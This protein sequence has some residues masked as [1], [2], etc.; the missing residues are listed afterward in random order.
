MRPIP[1]ATPMRFDRIAIRESASNSSYY[2]APRKR[3]PEAVDEKVRY[4]TVENL[5][6]GKLTFL[7]DI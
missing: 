6:V 7:R 2:I 4:V 5:V 3:A 1:L